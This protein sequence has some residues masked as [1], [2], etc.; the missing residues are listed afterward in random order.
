MTFIMVVNQHCFNNISCLHCILYVYSNEKSTHFQW[1][2]AINSDGSSRIYYKSID[3]VSSISADQAKIPPFKLYSFTWPV[4]SS[5][6]LTAS[7]L[8]LPLRQ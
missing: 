3:T 4:A 8:L 1:G 2:I 7:A 5:N 6:N